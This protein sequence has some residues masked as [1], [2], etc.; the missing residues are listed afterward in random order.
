MPTVEVDVEHDDGA[1]GQASEQI[2]VELH[3]GLGNGEG[4]Q[5]KPTEIYF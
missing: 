2:S 1:C 5:T 4:E 3:K